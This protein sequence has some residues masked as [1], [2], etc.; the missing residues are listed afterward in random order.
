MRGFYVHQIFRSYG[1]LSWRCHGF[2]V[3][4]ECVRFFAA[5]AL[6]AGEVQPAEEVAPATTAAA[7]QWPALARVGGGNSHRLRTVGKFPQLN[8]VTVEPGGEPFWEPFT[9]PFESFSNDTWP[10]EPFANETNATADLEVDVADV[11]PLLQFRQP[12]G[13]YVQFDN[14]ATLIEPWQFNSP[15]IYEPRESSAP[16]SLSRWA[17]AGVQ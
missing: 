4:Q 6:A 14:S 5:G 1:E 11:D 8:L 16:C 10:F 17:G 13:T 9:E 12:A 15:G 3:Y 7:R 2:N